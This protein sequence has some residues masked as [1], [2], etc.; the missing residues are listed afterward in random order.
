MN[1]WSAEAWRRVVESAPEGIVICDATA[2]DC[3][4]VF[5]NAAFAQMCG[6]PAAAL[7]GTNLRILQGT[8]RDQE[9]R[10]RLREAVAKASRHACW[11]ATTAPTAR[12]S[13]TRR[14]IQP[15][16]TAGKLTHFVGYH[17]DASERLKNAERQRNGLALLAARGP[18]HRLC[19]HAPT[20]RSCCSATGSSR[21]ATRT[22]SG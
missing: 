5:V 6:Y 16:R 11:C 4:V 3:P 17:R 21:S 14:S 22:R 1:N 13:G 8:D 10:T 15:V 19:I 20:S 2:A 7:L 9:A 18:P 12:C